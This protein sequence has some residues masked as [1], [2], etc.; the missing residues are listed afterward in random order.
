MGRPLGGGREQLLVEEMC[1]IL[2]YLQWKADWWKGQSDRHKDSSERL[3]RGLKVYA[4]KQV[5]VYERL[6]TRTA[7]YWV[8]YLEW[9]R[10]LPAWILPYKAAARKVH[11]QFA[12]PTVG[13]VPDEERESSDDDHL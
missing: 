2:A 9:L 3:R 11:P 1:R 12:M 5:A 6:A 10:P 7:S 13:G 8:T 4:A